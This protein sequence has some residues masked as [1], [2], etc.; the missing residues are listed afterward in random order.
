MTDNMWIHLWN[1]CHVLLVCVWHIIKIIR[2]NFYK[3]VTMFKMRS[4]GYSI[5]GVE[6]VCSRSFSILIFH[7]SF[8]ITLLKSTWYPNR[9][10]VFFLSIYKLG[11][12]QHFRT[13]P[14]IWTWCDSS[15]ISGPT[16]FL[17]LGCIFNI[18]IKNFVL[19]IKASCLSTL[20]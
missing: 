2:A 7:L 18:K 10:Y 20:L 5:Y 17:K 16:E 9:V 12:K 13:S 15:F 8:R 11:E 4:M 19:F 6:I 1:H 3:A 14:S